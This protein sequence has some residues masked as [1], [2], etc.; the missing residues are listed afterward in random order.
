ME[1]LEKREDKEDAE[2]TRSVYLSTRPGKSAKGRG[3]E[4]EV[5]NKGNFLGRVK[6]LV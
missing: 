1:G 6:H 2:D 4:I 3:Y 5:V